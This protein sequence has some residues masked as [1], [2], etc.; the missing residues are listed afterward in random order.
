[1]NICA[2]GHWSPRA[3]QKYICYSIAQSHSLLVSMSFS[4]LLGDNVKFYGHIISSKIVKDYSLVWSLWFW[5]W[6]FLRLT[7][8]SFAFIVLPLP[9]LEKGVSPNLSRLCMKT[10]I[11]TVVWVQNWHIFVV[12]SYSIEAFSSLVRCHKIYSIQTRTQHVI[13]TAV[14][15]AENEKA[16][17]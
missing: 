9:L 14:V 3:L 13:V 6:S 5:F 16:K 17:S 1:M 12:I 4:N 15:L 2:D 8:W 7:N 11:M 10:A